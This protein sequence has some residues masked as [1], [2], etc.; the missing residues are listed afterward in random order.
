MSG[1]S[2]KL[3]KDK[4]ASMLPLFGSIEDEALVTPSSCVAEPIP[5]L[6]LRISPTIAKA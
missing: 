5:K 1:G 3:L 4:P 2:P 6:C